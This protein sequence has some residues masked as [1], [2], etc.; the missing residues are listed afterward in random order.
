M[1]ESLMT[2][3]ARGDDAAVAEIIDQYGSLVWAIARRLTRNPSD[4]EDAVQE[5]FTDVW[6]S[7]HRFDANAGSE[8][9]FITTIARRRLIDRMRRVANRV[10]MESADN[11]DELGFHTPDTAADVSVEAEQAAR[12]LQKLRPE[13]RQVIELSVM[14]GL[15]HS[16]IAAVTGMPLGTVKTFMRRGLIEVREL[17]GVAAPTAV[18]GQRSM[19]A[20]FLQDERIAD[21]L[22]RQ[23]T[24]GLDEAAQRELDSLL[25]AAPAAA[26]DA[27]AGAASAVTLAG[28]LP[29]E[30]LP[31]A[32]R[33]KLIAQGRAA[34]R[35][36]AAGRV[37]SLADRRPASAPVAQPAGSRM[38][39]YAAAASLLL[40][41]AA[42]WPQLGTEPAQVAV[43]P[44]VVT[45]AEEREALLAAAPEA[46]QRTWSG[47]EDP[48]SSAVAGDVVWDPDT[49]T[50]YMRFTGLPA[51][52]PSAEQYQLWIF[53]GTRDDRYPVDGG[54]FDI[55]PGATEVVVPIRARLPVRNAALFAVTVEP[56]G[57]VVVSSRERIV[58]LAQVAS[59]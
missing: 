2:R 49:Q 26:R 54:V 16:E 29:L 57:G 34:V 47:T 59:S 48:A 40:A 41:V 13:Q 25:G 44:P 14:Q 4:A 8:K 30:P 28:N 21:L 39:W 32:L 12:V 22:V 1:T 20:Q 56:P 24:E 17:M 58:A 50:G 11:L 53:D 52:N 37:V 46:V 38:G 23:E 27:L 33:E 6:R 15:S 36:A 45:P 35:E 19:N 18:R 7:A 43:T 42:W 31:A 3:V 51:N 5:I 9:V 10:Q 55:P